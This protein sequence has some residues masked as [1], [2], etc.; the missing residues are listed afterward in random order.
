[1][2]NL[3]VIAVLLVLAGA[4]SAN[5]QTEVGVTPKAEWFANYSF[6]RVGSGSGFDAGNYN[7]GWNTAFVGNVNRWLG[8]VTDFSGHYGHQPIRNGL[9][10]T[11]GSNLHT[12]MIGPR[13]TSRQ[14]DRY[15]PFVHALFGA[16]RI[17]RDIPMLVGTPLISS[18]TS[19]EQSVSETAWPFAMKWAAEWMSR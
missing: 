14:S 18:F 7:W 13:F 6:A 19:T 15:T 3:R 12:F 8:I 9:G 17:H 1:M 10:A 16:A 4:V 11:V 2:R 5:A